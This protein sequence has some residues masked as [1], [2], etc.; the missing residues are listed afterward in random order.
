MV[1]I[2]P[3]DTLLTAYG[4]FKLY[5]VSQLPVLEDGKVVGIIDESDVLLAVVREPAHFA[6]PVSRRT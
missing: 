1:T 6:E 2:A 5:D 3:D 4:R